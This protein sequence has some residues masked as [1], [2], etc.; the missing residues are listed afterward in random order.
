MDYH[1]R[2]QQLAQQRAYERRIR[3]QGLSGLLAPYTLKQ[4]FIPSQRRIERW[5]PLLA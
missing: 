4:P 2:Y 5:V 3:E 1:Q